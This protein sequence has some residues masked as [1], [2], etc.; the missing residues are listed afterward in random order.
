MNKVLLFFGRF[1][2]RIGTKI[3]N[4]RTL[5]EQE[6]LL[7]SHTTSMK[8][9]VIDADGVSGMILFDMAGEA[10]FRATNKDHSF[11]DYKILHNDLAVIIEPGYEASFYTYENED[12]NSLDHAPETLGLSYDIEIT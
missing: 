11:K 6:V 9:K 1:L 2:V 5:K 3:L 7:K 4:M 8:A 12:N 10:Y